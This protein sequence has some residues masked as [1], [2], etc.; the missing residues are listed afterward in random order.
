M[1]R[2]LHTA[3]WHIDAPLRDFTGQQRRQLRTAMLEL[4]GKIAD[5]AARE[6]CDLCLIA[7]DVFDGSYT[8]EGYEAVFYALER[9][10]IPVFIAPGNHDPYREGSPWTAEVWPENVYLFHTND[11]T[12]YQVEDLECVVYGAAFTSMDCPA[13]LEGFQADCAERYAL[14]VLHGDPTNAAS[15]YNPITA[16]QVR[17]AGL[18]YVALGHIHAPGRFGAGASMCAWPG[19]P[20]G[21]GFDET[22]TKGVLV[23]EVEEGV[24]IRFL[25]LEVPRFFDHTVSAG[26]NP[27]A[28]VEA[29]L[30]A[31]GSPDYIRIRVTGQVQEG[32]MARLA[33]AL[34]AWPNLRLLDETTPC[35][36]IWETAGADSLTGLFF[37]ILRDGAREADPQTAAHLELAAKL[38]RAILEGREVELP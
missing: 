36:D 23:A 7:G 15:P 12:A 33:E 13:L 25:P 8:R 24:N 11:I 17:E 32:A 29:V 31:G 14:M 21:H 19:C 22:G 4:P 37:R 6:G 30:P 10:Q 1:I 18:D 20:M 38:S 35:R 5:I 34:T 26:E 9:M 27:L 28:A 16:G 2:I 3:D